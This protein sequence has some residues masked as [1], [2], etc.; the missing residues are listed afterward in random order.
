MIKKLLS[1]LF[2]GTLFAIITPIAYWW[3]FS[4]MPLEGFFSGVILLAA[5]GFL[6]GAILGLMFP[7]VFG[8]LFEML[9]DV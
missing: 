2:G 3:I 7:R 8:F 6:V 5:C 1:A 4:S 9:F